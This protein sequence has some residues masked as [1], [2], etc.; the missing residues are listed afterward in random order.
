MELFTLENM[1]MIFWF[2]ERC[3]GVDQLPK[4]H[5]EGDVFKHSIQV[6]SLAFRESSDVDLILAAYLHDVGKIVLSREHPRIGCILLRPYVSSKTLFLIKHHMRIWAF[7]N[8]EMEKLSKCRFLASHPYISELIQLARW[9]HKGRNPNKKSI[10]N[11]YKIIDRLNKCAEQHFNV[12]DYLKGHE[13]CYGLND[14]K[15]ESQEDIGRRI[16]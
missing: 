3:R 8:G 6:G 1:K 4:W 16:I 7:L 9:D 5:P 2:I 12:P 11:K 13:G 14:D 10:Y 15:V